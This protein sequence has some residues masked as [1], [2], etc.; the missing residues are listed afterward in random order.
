MR[1]LAE[2]PQYSNQ[3][4]L[5]HALNEV[6]GRNARVRVH[7]HIEWAVAEE[8]EAATGFIQLR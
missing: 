5:F 1:F 8:T 2:L 3:L 4:F 7:A 6:T